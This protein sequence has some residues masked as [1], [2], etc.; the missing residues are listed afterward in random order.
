MIAQLCR[1]TTKFMC[2]Q[3]L[4]VNLMR[5]FPHNMKTKVSECFRLISKKSH[6]RLI[7]TAMLLLP[8]GLGKLGYVLG[9]DPPKKVHLLLIDLSI[10][11]FDYVKE[12][13]HSSNRQETLVYVCVSDQQLLCTAKFHKKFCTP[14]LKQFFTNTV[15][16]FFKLC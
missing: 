8:L 16:S 6:G 10:K 9:V 1:V 4:Y 11:L 7:A 15:Q 2:H 14:G 13:Q 5:K 3:K 12:K